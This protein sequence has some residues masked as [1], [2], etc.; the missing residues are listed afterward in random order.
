MQRRSFFLAAAALVLAGAVAA[1]ACGGAGDAG[2]SAAPTDDG[3]GRASAGACVG[4]T[5]LGEACPLPAPVRYGA[6]GQSTCGNGVRDTCSSATETCDGADLGGATCQ[7]LGY[8]GGSLACNAGCTYDAKGCG[9]CSVG[10]HVPSCANAVVD[11]HASEIALARNEASG[12]V[13]VAW[14]SGGGSFGLGNA[15]YGF[16]ILDANLGVLAR[17]GC[18]GAGDASSVGASAGAVA[19]AAT[20]HGWLL[21]TDSGDGIDLRALDACGASTAPPQHVTGARSPFLAAR[22]GDDGG[23][24]GGPLFVYSSARQRYA[25]LVAA[26][27]TAE[28]TANVA[29]ATPIDPGDGSAIFVGDAFLYAERDDTS[30]IDGVL[31]ARV[32]LDGSVTSGRPAGG[33]TE[34]PTLASDRDGPL[35]TY[36]DFGTANAGGGAGTGGLRWTRLDARGGAVGEAHVLPV[37]P[38]IYARVPVVA[39]RTATALVLAPGASASELPH[40]ATIDAVPITASPVVGDGGAADATDAN[41]AGLAILSGVPGTGGARVASG[42]SDAIVAWLGETGAIGLLTLRP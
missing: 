7:L 32:A 9:G 24:L 39:T 2:A 40:S 25:E 6:C 4:T 10:D 33:E 21:A 35:L 13:A 12:T 11:A 26:D 22:A 28:T 5:P 18:L 27:G 14:R 17:S 16:A 23:V 30:A 38:G 15:S 31:V 42:K 34:Y 20:P 37:A 41:P 3:S 1:V 29:I 36:A 19:I 8:T